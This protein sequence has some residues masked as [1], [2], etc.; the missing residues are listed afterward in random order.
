MR[1][2]ISFVLVFTTAL[3]LQAQETATPDQDTT[4]TAN[5][6]LKSK[7]MIS[8]GSGGVYIGKKRQKKK[9][10]KVTL[11]YFML[12]LAFNNINDR[13]DYSNPETQAFLH[14][15]PAQK[16]A[17]V[18][19][20]NEGKSM[21]VNIYPALVR[22]QL[23]RTKNQK[24]YLSSG[25]GLQIYNFRYKSN[26]AYANDAEPFVFMDSVHFTK[27]KLAVAYLQIPLMLT[28]K[29]RISEKHWI[30]YGA[31]I[32]AGY[33]V[34]SWMKQKST[35]RGKQKNHDPFNFQQFNLC[36]TGELGVNDYFRIIGGVQLTPLHQSALQQYP[37][38]FGLRF[39]G[40]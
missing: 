34:S 3:Q 5:D 9:D 32:Q 10:K 1:T 18:F 26:I 38:F 23:M 15:D 24:I 40:I 17:N 8:I 14:M 27:N 39:L 16:N 36:V 7:K 29:S 21:S 13:T 19:R 25:L 12:D 11:Q 4:Q 30:V 35:E 6:S 31:G 20:L 37:Y 2:F 28:M 22:M 33:K